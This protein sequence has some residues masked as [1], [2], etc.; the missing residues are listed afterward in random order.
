MANED[1][2]SMNASEA[3]DALED[4]KFG[5]EWFKNF[6]PKSTRHTSQLK[7]RIAALEVRLRALVGA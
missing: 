5:V 2:R 7:K 6:D 1:V 3:K 4:C